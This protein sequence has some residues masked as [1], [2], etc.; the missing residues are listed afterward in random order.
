MELPEVVE[1]AG[2][3]PVPLNNALEVGI[4]GEK[5]ELF[6][7]DVPVVDGHVELLSGDVLE[8]DG[9][10]GDGEEGDEVIGDFFGFF[11]T[12]ASCL[13]FFFFSFFA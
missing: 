7:G 8:I 11:V 12:D 4:I 2:V 1:E 6:P 10:E 9:E 5:V 3:P 13:P